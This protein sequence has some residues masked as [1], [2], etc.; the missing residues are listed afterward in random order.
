M[1]LAK[2]RERRGGG[3]EIGR[4]GDTAAWE[5]AVA[6]GAPLPPRVSEADV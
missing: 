5:R 3:A 1:L 2:L 6:A 4:R